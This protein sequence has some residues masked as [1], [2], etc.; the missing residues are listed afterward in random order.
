M[1]LSI[2]SC[3]CWQSVYVLWRNVYLGLLPI[4]ELGCLFFWYW[5]AWVACM[6]WRRH[7]FC[8][9]V[10]MFKNRQLIY[11]HDL[12]HFS[13]ILN[14][15]QGT[16]LYT[17]IIHKY[18]YWKL[19]KICLSCPPLKVSEWHTVPGH[20]LLIGWD[21][22]C[23]LECILELSNPFP[24]SISPAHIFWDETQSQWLFIIISSSKQWFY[25]QVQYCSPQPISIQVSPWASL[26][27]SSLREPIPGSKC[28]G[29]S[30]ASE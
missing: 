3:V 17:S 6:F 4:F 13:F 26:S 29:P 30:A 19:Q 25:M 20:C 24:L 28:G 18:E 16:E 1:T 22:V 12:F 21:C 11:N 27:D 5:A 8:I 10:T 7:F 14:P 23:L 9:P 2:L 15:F